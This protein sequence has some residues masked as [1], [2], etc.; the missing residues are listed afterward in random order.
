MSNLEA[1]ASAS[2]CPL[3]QFCGY[4]PQ[5]GPSDRAVVAEAVCANVSFPDFS[6]QPVIRNR[7]K[8]RDARQGR[9][10][11]SSPAV[12]LPK[13]LGLGKIQPSV[14]RIRND[15]AIEALLQNYT[16]AGHPY[17]VLLGLDNVLDPMKTEG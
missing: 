17:N 5:S 1:R 2:E 14:I 6:F 7:S 3:F 16:I 8:R 9:P 13:S 10:Y 11:P 4:E 15:L 12:F